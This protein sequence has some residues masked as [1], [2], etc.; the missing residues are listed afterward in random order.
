[1]IKASKKIYYLLPLLFGFKS[2]IF[3]LIANKEEI[4][5]LD[6]FYLPFQEIIYFL[7]TS[8]IIFVGYRNNYKIDRFFKVIG[9]LIFIY[10]IFFYVMR[11]L[12]NKDYFNF[13]DYGKFYN[14]MLYNY[15]FHI[16]GIIFGMITYVLQKGYAER[17]SEILDKIYLLSSAK[18]I[19]T[20]K[21]QKRKTLNI[22]VIISLIIIILI[23]FFQQIIASFYGYSEEELINYKNNIFSQIILFFDADLFVILSYLVSF[24]QYIK[25]DNKLNSFLCHNFWAIFN[26]FYF[27]FI[28]L[29]NPIILY[30]I[31]TTDTKIIFNLSHCFLYTFICGILVFIITIVMYSI[32]ELPLK[33]LIQYLIKTSENNLREGLSGIGNNNQDINFMDNVTASLT[34]LIEEDEEGDK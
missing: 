21:K 33:K 23:S 3:P 6:Y 11:H 10:R 28:I 9:I 2:H 26:N 22:L 12:D 15:S 13:H 17:D 19:K 31:Y 1:M 5:L 30:I 34:D 4:N 24:C 25:G 7:I 29:I 18:L 16:A 27:T 8:F 14:S 20:I 32:F